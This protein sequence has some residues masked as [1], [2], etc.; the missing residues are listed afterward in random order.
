MS[1]ELSSD[2]KLL[3]A[4]E[5]KLR[6]SRELL[7]VTESIQGAAEG[8]KIA[9]VHSLLAERQALMQRVEK[10]D[11]GIREI[12]EGI[13]SRDGRRSWRSHDRIESLWKAIEG[14]FRT[15][16]D[17]DRAAISRIASQQKEI[18]DELLRIRSSSKSVYAYRNGF[19]TGPRFMDVRR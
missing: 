6:V 5:E 8:E 7:E 13:F 19:G 1:E 9:R 11:A 14:V 12:D 17:L 3:G 4:V 2:G 18:K 15:A 16:A 10:I